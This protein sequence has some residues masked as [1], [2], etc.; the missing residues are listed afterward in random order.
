MI[1]DE[2]LRR[3]AQ[4]IDHLGTPRNAFGLWIAATGIFAG[5]YLMEPFFH[6][7]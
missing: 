2:I 3:T 7:L 1:D 6:Y 5:A 4:F